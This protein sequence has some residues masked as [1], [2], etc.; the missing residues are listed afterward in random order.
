MENQNKLYDPDDVFG[1][2][3]DRWKNGEVGSGTKKFSQMG[4]IEID[5]LV[6]AIWPN[7]GPEVTF[8]DILERAQSLKAN[9]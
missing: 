1:T 9:L 8:F 2:W 5:Q 7:R 6:E 4:L 3:K